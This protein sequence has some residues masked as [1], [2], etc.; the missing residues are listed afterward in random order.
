M[1]SI[2]IHISL[3]QASLSSSMWVAGRA[4]HSLKSVSDRPQPALRVLRLDGASVNGSNRRIQTDTLPLSLGGAPNV[5]CWTPPPRLFPRSRYSQPG[6]MNRRG[7]GHRWR[8]F[9]RFTE[10][11]PCRAIGGWSPVLS[12]GQP[13][14]ARRPQFVYRAGLVL[15]DLLGSERFRPVALLGHGSLA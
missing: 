13:V 10:G 12:R 15:R 6:V 2:G 9:W 14:G 8:G 1:T 11:R 3:N 4:E 7:R 5:P